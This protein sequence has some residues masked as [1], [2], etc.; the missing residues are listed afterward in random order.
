MFP[1]GTHCGALPRGRRAWRLN[2]SFIHSPARFGQPVRS[3][4]Q[5]SV[6]PNYFFSA[7]FI[8]SAIS[9]A[10]YSCRGCCGSIAAA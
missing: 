1:V 9:F 3:T 8:T 5:R 7:R 4:P 10:A 2:N 6:S